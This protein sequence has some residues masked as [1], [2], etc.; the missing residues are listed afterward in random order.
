MEQTQV[1]FNVGQVIQHKLFK[2][3]GVVVDVDALF[4]NTDEWYDLMAKTRPSKQQPWYHILVDETDYIT[5]VAEQNMLPETSGL[6]V[7][8]PEI[9]KYFEC[10]DNGVYVTKRTNQ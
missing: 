5:Y 2:Y 4:Q 8:H 9:E 10:L 1:K 6:P 3:R 7:K